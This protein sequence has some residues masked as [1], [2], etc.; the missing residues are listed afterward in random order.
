MATGSSSSTSEFALSSPPTDGITSL[1]FVTNELLLVSSWDAG[2][3]LY[4][5][6][7]NDL[8]ASYY[9]KAGVL[10]CCFADADTCFSGGVDRVVRMF[11]VRSHT[12]SAIGAHDNAVK[13]VAYSPQGLVL[14]G[15]WDGTL[16]GWDP[17]ANNTSNASNKSQL[18]LD[19]PDK[20]YSMDL[21]GD[22]LV[23]ATAGRHVWIYDPRN[24]SSPLYKR[25]SA[26][27]FQTR[28]VKVFP[29]LTGYA[30]SSV[31]GRV[32][33]EYFDTAPEV[34]ARRYAFKCHRH[35][36]RT[37]EQTVYPVN[38]MA[39]HPVYGT[40]TTGGCDGMVNVWDGQNKKRLCYYR[41]Y[42]T[43]ISALAFNPSGRLL[44][45]ASS[46]TFEEG[47]KDHPAD[48]IFIR[49]VEDVDVKPRT[50]PSQ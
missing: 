11:D 30:L 48:S 14:S 44:A 25:E 10:D 16:K 34:Q 31:E 24:L 4:D 43:S 15:S 3:R 20:I 1:S 5:V 46:Y 29:D 39:F 37:G 7:Q 50:R 28:C 12:E 38:A 18:S 26:L 9:H 35:T 19:L 47:E 22:K 6:E 42:P 21:R 23:V 40:F 41:Q 13:C 33:I 8:L 17:K 49:T 2:V 32:A 36:A 27:K 45:I